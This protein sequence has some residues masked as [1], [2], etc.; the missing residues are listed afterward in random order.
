MIK[1][2]LTLILILLFVVACG[3]DTSSSDSAEIATTPATTI[4][5][6]AP[7]ATIAPTD[8][9][10][11]TAEPTD[12]PTATAPPTDAPTAT[13]EPTTEP[14]VAAEPTATIEP[15][16]E[17]EVASAYV[18]KT[19]A[20]LEPGELL[21]P[22]L[23]EYTVEN[24]AKVFNVRLQEGQVEFV[25]GVT[26]ETKGFNGDYLGHTI[27]VS[28]GDDVVLNVI[29]E[30]DQPSTVH[31]H[32]L[33][34]PAEMDGTPHQLIPA[35]ETWQA[36][37]PILNEAATMWY[38]PHAHGTTAQQVVEGLA[39]MYIIDDGNSMSLDIPN[40]YG[41]DDIPLIVQDRNFV[42]GVMQGIVRGGGAGVY[43]GD[44]ML[45]NG[46]LDAWAEVPAKQIR[47]RILNGSLSRIY[48]FGFADGR[49]F[50]QI[51]SDGGLLESPVPT[52]QLLMATGE[53]AE[54]VVDLSDGEEAVFM[55]LD[56]DR[57]RGGDN[58]GNYEILRLI[59]DTSHEMAE[60]NP[61][62]LP[63][64][65]N[66]IERW[67]EEDADNV[68]PLVLAGQVT[69]IEDPTDLYLEMDHDESQANA[70]GRGIPING[71][72]MDM[73]RIDEVVMMGDIEIWE[74]SNNG[75]P[76]P[77]HIHDVQFQIL[78]RDGVPPE[79]YEAGWKDTVLVSNGETV[80]VIMKFDTYANET[81]PYMFH[82][83]ILQHEDGGMMGQ[84]IV[85]DPEAQANGDPSI[86]DYTYSL[87]SAPIFSSSDAFSSDNPF[88]C[89]IPDT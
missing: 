78:D 8:A 59:P 67:T 18:P 55:T 27:R 40:I 30:L 79:P 13:S 44:Q 48:S 52:T 17:P 4:A 72:V 75:Q 86:L 81:I 84:F 26:T 56:D 70:G 3:S 23:L 50:Y 7:T 41:L 74:I 1:R 64:T 49:E 5:E 37:Y 25:E 22:P 11:S 15:T 21:I 38:H 6:V 87:A 46:R 69:T 9:P 42:D 82:C 89:A 88:I 80:R 51:A 43:Y 58:G 61:T 76:H 71:K 32:G 65:L 57:L 2:L 33:H 28:E 62:P 14:T 54:I 10:M 77:V 83:H 68:R 73:E 19:L 36:S 60:S 31:W 47:L 53:R 85:V 29:N 35:G 12:E 45:A 24:G 66:V 16:A 63:E 39:G 20:D 34:V